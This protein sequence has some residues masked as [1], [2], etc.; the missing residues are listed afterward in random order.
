MTSQMQY[1][2]SEIHEYSHFKFSGIIV[3]LSSHQ[4][5]LTALLPLVTNEKHNLSNLATETAIMVFYQVFA[6]CSINM[7]S[8]RTF[9]DI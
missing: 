2:N 3:F 6:K 9:K 8:S 7:I 5:K 4:D 1:Y